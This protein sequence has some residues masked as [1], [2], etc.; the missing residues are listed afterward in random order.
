MQVIIFELEEQ[1]YGIKT[2]TVEEISRLLDITPVPNAP[3]YIK[4]LI[5]LRGNVISLIEI[6]KLLEI[7]IKKPYTNIIIANIDH[8]MIGMLVGDVW[9]VME[10]QEEEIEITDLAEEEKKG[11][12]G[13]V[14][15][16]DRIIN[17]VDLEKLFEN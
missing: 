1:H 4:G 6:A 9:E 12:I 8:E 15:I 17:Y 5:N 2:D 3:Y 7:E 10:I 14:Q 11:V 13:I 16:Q